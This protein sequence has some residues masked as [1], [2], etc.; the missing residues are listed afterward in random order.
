MIFAGQALARPGHG[1]FHANREMPETRC[2]H[3]HAPRRCRSTTKAQHEPRFL[4]IRLGGH[5]RHRQAP[6]QDPPEQPQPAHRQNS[7]FA[8]HGQSVA[9]HVPLLLTRRPG[10]DIVVKSNLI[11]FSPLSP[12]GAREMA[13][14]LESRP[15]LARSGRVLSGKRALSQGTVMGEERRFLARGPWAARISHGERRAPG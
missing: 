11:H 3:P 10:M 2:M 15:F 14:R 5:G 9:R 12:D 7:L 1:L 4:R 8:A 13:S 6:S